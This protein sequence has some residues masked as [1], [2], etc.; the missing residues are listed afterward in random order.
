M[1]LASRAIQSFER[2]TLW[3][4]GNSREVT[5]CYGGAGPKASCQLDSTVDSTVMCTRVVSFC[6]SN[7]KRVR[8]WSIPEMLDSLRLFVDIKLRF[9]T[10]KNICLKLQSFRCESCD[11]LRSQTKFKSRVC[12]CGRENVFDKSTKC[13]SSVDRGSPRDRRNC[14]SFLPEYGPFKDILPHGILKELP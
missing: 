1:L 13:T 8:S 4:L 3:R 11:F 2:P 7:M 12:V 6:I 10:Y 14:F 9:W 5:Q